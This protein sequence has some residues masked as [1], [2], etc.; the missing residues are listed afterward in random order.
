MPTN[1][2][3]L[4][5][6]AK[7]AAA[8]ATTKANAYKALLPASNAAKMEAF[9]KNV[10]KGAAFVGLG[11]VTAAMKQG[12]DEISKAVTQAKQKQTAMKNL[13][14]IEKKAVASLLS[15]MN[16]AKTT[17]TTKEAA[18]NKDPK[19]QAAVNAAKDAKAA[20]DK[21]AANYNA[22]V[23]KEKASKSNYDKATAELAAVE[24]N[25]NEKKQAVA[26]KLKDAQDL[27]NKANAEAQKA[28]SDSKTKYNALITAYNAWKT[29]LT[30][31]ATAGEAW[32]KAARNS[33]IADNVI[34]ATA[35]GAKIIIGGINAAF[36]KGLEMVANCRLIKGTKL[37]TVVDI[38]NCCVDIATTGLKDFVVGLGI[39]TAAG[40]VSA[41]YNGGT[42]PE[43]AA[44][45]IDAT[46]KSAIS[47]YT[48]ICDKSMAL[49]KAYDPTLTEADL[50]EF[51]LYVKDTAKARLGK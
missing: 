50:Q 37:G 4:E 22:A 39:D 46:K 8:T 40:L 2:E 19:N 29:A 27:Y 41:I 35:T 45:V 47:S 42:V 36:Q 16:T 21:A 51:F 13:Y 28:A 34:N 44:K 7:D 3:V 11:I 1:V 17:L 20:Y 43:I 24:K 12:T 6:K 49:L 23:V 25:A 31:A 38:A 5:T 18:R 33:K 14:D 32:E 15:T 48:D 30:Q 9:K 10:A 26:K